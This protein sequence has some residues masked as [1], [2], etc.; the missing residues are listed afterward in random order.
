[1]EVTDT[2]ENVAHPLYARDVAISAV[3][4]FIGEKRTKEQ[5]IS[6]NLRKLEFSSGSLGGIGVAL[7]I[8]L[9]YYKVLLRKKKKEGQV[10]NSEEG[11]STT[12]NRPNVGDRRNHTHTDTRLTFDPE[13]MT[14]DPWTCDPVHQLNSRT[15]KSYDQFWY[16]NGCTEDHRGIRP[17]LTRWNNRRSAQLDPDEGLERRRVRR[18]ITEQDLRRLA[19]Q[20]GILELTSKLSHSTAAS[21]P[22][23]GAAVR[24]VEALINNREEEYAHKAQ[25]GGSSRRNRESYCNSCHRTFRKSQPNSRKGGLHSKIKDCGDFPFQH[26]ETDR[27]LIIGNASDASEDVRIRRRS[28]NVTFNLETLRHYKQQNSHSEDERTS[29][30]EER[31]GKYNSKVRLRRLKVK[32]NLSPRGKSKVHPKRRNEQGHSGGGGSKTSRGQRGAGKDPERKGKRMERHQKRK[33]PAK[34]KGSVEDGEEHKGENSRQTGQDSQNPSTVGRGVPES[35]AEEPPEAAQTADGSNTAEQLPPDP[36]HPQ[37]GCHQRHPAPAHPPRSVESSTSLRAGSFLPDAMAPGASPAVA[38]WITNSVPPS[39]ATCTSSLAPDGAP[40]TF[41][42]QPR[43]LPSA[44]VLPAPIPPSGF[45]S[46]LLAPQSKDFLIS[47][48]GSTAFHPSLPPPSG[49]SPLVEK[50]QSDPAREPAPQSGRDQPP[51]EAAQNGE[52]TLLQPES[53]SVEAE[54]GDGADLAE[55]LPPRGGG[56]SVQTGEAPPPSDR[57]NTLSTQAVAS[58]DTDGKAAQVLQ[59]QEWRAE[60]GGS[61]Q[62]RKL[63]L[64]L[65]EKTSSRPLTA[66]ERKIR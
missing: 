55:I 1:M 63:R 30:G 10:E 29:R 2:R 17:N 21:H 57:S 22:G 24:R 12:A 6:D 60:E 58:A 26:R 35:P 33:T 53:A 25:G 37:D 56:G 13:A 64:V 16:S 43:L 11:D 34:V 49:S 7:L 4:C 50:L 15:D 61:N 5:P 48:V 42:G 62:R 9:I 66:L 38:G 39:T 18:L 52:E 28:R 45:A 40:G 3:I 54:N 47:T 51:S 65:P 32:F 27:D 14:L 41:H 31:A 20:Q 59:Q 36:Q 46:P 8:V 44:S 23:K 19:T